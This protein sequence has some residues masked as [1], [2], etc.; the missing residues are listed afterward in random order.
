MKLH[1]FLLLCPLLLLGCAAEEHQDLR[2]WM[3]EEAKSMKGKVAPLPEIT[4]FPVVA[5]ET[6]TL[7]PP[8][9][10]GKIVTLEAVADKTAPDRTRPQQPLEIFPIEDLKVVGIIT[11]GTV[12]Y[13]LIQTPPPNKPKHVRVGE[14]MGRSFGK[15]TAISK[16]GVT[17]LET[18]K[19][20]N[21]AWV[22]QE[23]VL[24]VPKE[25]G[26]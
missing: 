13:A 21:G 19:D 25:G 2:T 23:K 3:R 12:P 10:S 20:A 7:T 11:A 18:V 22:E 5:Y 14:Y 16:D 17:V 8:F 9:A 1:P 24:M 6:E 15:I 4:A 26:N